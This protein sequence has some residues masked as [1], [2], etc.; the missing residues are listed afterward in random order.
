MSYVKESETSATNPMTNQLRPD[1]PS[2]N[3]I[4]RESRKTVGKLAIDDPRIICKNVNVFYG[5]NQAINDLSIE[6][7]NQEVISFIGPSG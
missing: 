4:D 1:S 2:P 7:G 5:E 6:I 3:K